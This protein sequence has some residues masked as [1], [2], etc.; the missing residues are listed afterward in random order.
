MNHR[1]HCWS[2][3]NQDMEKEQEHEMSLFGKG[4][5]VVSCEN[6]QHPYQDIKQTG[7]AQG[8]TRK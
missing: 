1:K 6:S 2:C 3:W 8:K 4:K 7:A 5:Y